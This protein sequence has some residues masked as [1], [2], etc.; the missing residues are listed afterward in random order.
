ME[1]KEQTY[2]AAANRLA[3][4]F[5]AFLPIDDEINAP[6]LKPNDKV[7][8]LKVDRLHPRDFIFYEQKGH[9]FIRRIIQIKEN[10]YFVCGDKEKEVRYVNQAEILGKIISR[11]RGV[12]RLSFQLKRRKKFYTFKKMLKGKMLL[13]N[14]PIYEDETSLSN[15]YELALQQK[16]KNEEE[17]KPVSPQI[18]ENSKDLRL[19]K[20]LSVFKSPTE[21][22]REYMTSSQENKIQNGTDNEN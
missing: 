19:E 14:H 15:T 17:K 1:D 22:V 16:K 5:I 21:R 20:E 8:L 18:T 4:G 9:F 6:L 7:A 10:S 12:K 11:E 3:G 2:E 13:R